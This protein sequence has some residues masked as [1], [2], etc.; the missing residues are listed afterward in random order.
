M[1]KL[2]YRLSSSRSFVKLFLIL[3]C[4]ALPSLFAQQAV[5]QEDLLGWVPDCAPNCPADGD[6]DAHLTCGA[7]QGLTTITHNPPSGSSVLQQGTVD[8]TFTDTARTCTIGSP[9][10][11]STGFFQETAQCS[12]TIQ[13]ANLS[14]TCADNGD[15]TST[16]TVTGMCPSQQ[17]QKQSGAIG[18]GG[19]IDCRA[20]PN[21]TFCTYQG[22]NPVGNT[23]G[24]CRWNIGFGKLQGSNVVSLSPNNCTD[25]FASP[26][27]SYT[28]TYAG[29]TCSGRF[30]SL[31]EMEQQSCHSD[32]WNG[33]TLATCDVQNIGGPKNSATGVVVNHLTV[34]TTYNQ[35]TVNATC[36]NIT[37]SGKITVTAL[38][39]PIETDQHQ[40]PIV[41]ENIDQRTITVNGFPVIPGTCTSP[42]VGMTTLACQ[43]NKCTL[44][45]HNII[46]NTISSNGKTATL[47]MKAQMF[48]ETFVTGDVETVQVSKTP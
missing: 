15:G 4:V 9:N 23:T 18:S 35:N 47:T 3:A 27:F 17:G 10:C 33:K 39:N 16:A 6:W 42:T 26:I 11:S 1:K 28:Q 14:E 2:F 22:T 5:A 36:V 44:D 29:Q 38:A 19:T 30:A 12:L 24:D 45:G 37:N 20:K 41:L 25:L 40:V 32:T 43:V 7:V 31:G 34:D 46:E 13:F 21:P 8:C 48:N